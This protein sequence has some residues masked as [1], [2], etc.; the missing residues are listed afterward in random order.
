MKNSLRM[1]EECE[2]YFMDKCINPV[3]YNI[4]KNVSKLRDKST[5]DSFIRFWS[6]RSDYENKNANKLLGIFMVTI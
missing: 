1:R 2:G 4:N 6:K 3:L 5:N